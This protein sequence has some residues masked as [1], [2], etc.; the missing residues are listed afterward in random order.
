MTDI[1]QL[2]RNHP[3]VATLTDEHFSTLES[4]G[5]AHVSFEPSDT[6]LQEGRV[7]DACFLIEEGEVALEVYVSGGDLRPVQVVRSGDVVGWSWLFP[8]H[9]AAFEAT[10]L[11]PI[12]ALSIDATLLR[13]KMAEDPAFGYAILVRVGKVAVSRLEA[14]RREIL[15]AYE[16]AI[17][18]PPKRP[19]HLGD[20][21]RAGQPVPR[22]VPTRLADA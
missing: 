13:E 7:A 4:C 3:F 18:E 5:V 20:K 17:D 21:R 10:A 19:T 9:R 15:E 2:P 16:R 6:I 12:K 1:G 22:D 8:P 11:S 14:S